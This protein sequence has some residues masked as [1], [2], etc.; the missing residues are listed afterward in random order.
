[1]I[2]TTD[3]LMTSPPFSLSAGDKEKILLPLF[4]ELTER[5]R[6][7][8][9]PYSSML[10]ALNYNSEAC[11]KLSEL[12]FLP[13][14]LF[15][16]LTLSSVSEE[17]TRTMVSSGTTGQNVSKLVIDSET[18]ALQRQALACIAAD[19]L[20]T[21]RI[22]MLILDTPDVLRPPL[23][24]TARGAGVLGFTVCASKRTFALRQDMSLDLDTVGEFL[25]NQAGEPFFVFGLTYMI[26]EHFYKVL[27]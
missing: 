3:K 9:Q 21:K 27:R 23:I 13:V 26:W 18:A 5:H 10:S 24:N 25:E 16:S 1:M 12:P 7:M 11:G 17:H 20:G 15:K 19:I 22:P 14:G 6:L 4:L 8:C 2:D